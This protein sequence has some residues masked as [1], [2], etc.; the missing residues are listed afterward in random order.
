MTITTQIIKETIPTLPLNEV[1]EIKN[2]TIETLKS[3][4][5]SGDITFETMLQY[6]GIISSQKFAPWW[7]KQVASILDLKR[8]TGFSEYDLKDRKKDI[9]YEMKYS[10][11][12][13]DGSYSF[14]QLYRS[15]LNP[16]YYFIFLFGLNDFVI[17]KLSGQDLKSSILVTNGSAAHNKN[18]SERR[19]TIKASSE[20]L[21][22]ILTFRDSVLE[23]KFKNAKYSV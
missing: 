6:K 18:I 7:E 17:S 11:E 13:N 21:K 3:K 14:P 5:A 8:I 20:E 4:C 15:N 12:G 9:Y 22:F 2:L 10:T 1:F 19:L 23:T 16:D